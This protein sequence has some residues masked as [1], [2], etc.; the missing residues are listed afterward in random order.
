MAIDPTDITE[1]QD[2]DFV[3]Q[4]APEIRAL[5]SYL[6]TVKSDLE[7]KVETIE[8]QLSASVDDL[9]TSEAQV[10]R[11]YIDTVKVQLENY[12]NNPNPGNITKDTLGLG[13]VENYATTSTIQDDQQKNASIRA[14]WLLKNS[15]ENA[16]TNLNKTLNTRSPRLS[17]IY[18]GFSTDRDIHPSQCNFNR[19]TY[20]GG[21]YWI[22]FGDTVSQAR[23]GNN[24]V[25]VTRADTATSYS[26]GGYPVPPKQVV[27][28]SNPTIIAAFYTATITG[29]SVKASIEHIG[30]PATHYRATTMASYPQVIGRIDYRPFTG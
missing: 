15:V 16:I 6:Q 7:T 12:I 2:S 10:L 8:S 5:K 4:A 21:E 24:V 11:D 3:L 17:T 1:P 28:G 22:Y 19:S 23:S 29:N 20:P 27:Q 25:Y 9:V 30:L 13:N 18:S 14:V 26:Q